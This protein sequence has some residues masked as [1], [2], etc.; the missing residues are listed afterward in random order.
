VKRGN[1]IPVHRA[2]FIGPTREAWHF[3]EKG[4]LE[5][6]REVVLKGTMRVGRLTDRSGLRVL[7]VQKGDGTMNR[8]LLMMSV[9]AVSLCLA[10]N[11]W[12]VSIDHVGGEIHAEVGTTYLNAGS[13]TKS[14]WPA[15]DGAFTDDISGASNLF[16]DGVGGYAYAAGHK[17]NGPGGDGYARFILSSTAQS[18]PDPNVSDPNTIQAITT[19]S[20]VRSGAT[21]LLMDA[22]PLTVAPTEADMLEFVLN[23]EAGE[24]FGQA[25]ELTALASL[26]G[27]LNSTGYPSICGPT[28]CYG[29]SGQEAGTATVDFIFQV[30]IDSDLEDATATPD[31]LVTSFTYDELVKKLEQVNMFDN[32]K[33]SGLPGALD[34]DVINA[35]GSL[36]P[37]MGATAATYMDGLAVGDTIWVYFEQLAKAETPG[38]IAGLGSAA[39]AYAVES[40]D[41]VTVALR[42]D[43]VDTVPEPSSVLLLGAGLT[44]LQLVARRRRKTSLRNRKAL[45]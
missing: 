26:A 29:P 33:S 1:Q 43:V 37:D 2:V 39:K 8:T 24:S 23:P 3:A 38:G 21:S 41:D 14:G 35:D 15:S 20:S 11:S 7:S 4:N 6:Y 45:A 18:K 28:M 9:S 40:V 34:S 31:K 27:T 13:L 32:E 30:Y 42:A 25:V 22:D 17:I 36:D 19:Y 10:Q 12:A 5:T 44:G 16:V